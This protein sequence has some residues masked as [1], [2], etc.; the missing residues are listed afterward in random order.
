[1][2]PLFRHFVVLLA[3]SLVMGACPDRDPTDRPDVTNDVGNADVAD[4]TDATMDDT[5]VDTG[6]C[7]EPL[8]PEGR[9]AFPLGLAGAPVSLFGD[10]SAPTFEAAFD[11]FSANGINVF[12]PWFGTQEVDG[13]AT[14]SGHFDYFLP[15]AFSGATRNCGV[16]D[17]YA[18]AAGRL[19]IL[20]P[21]F[22]FSDAEVEEALDETVFRERFALFQSECW[23]DNE[24]V[25]V[26]HESF[27]EIATQRVIADF[28]ESPGPLLSNAPAAATLLHELSDAPVYLVEAP[29]PDV[30]AAEE[31]LTDAQKEEII[32]Q[33]WDGVD[34]VV[35]GVDVF[36]FD[37]YPVPSLPLELSGDY[38]QIAQERAPSAARHLAV[39]QG[40]SYDAETAGTDPRRG[41]TRDETRFMAYHA[42]T[43]GA[44]ELLWYGA[45]ALQISNDDHRN[46]WE[47]VEALT[48]ELGELGAILDGDRVEIE[49]GDLAAVGFRAASGAV[50]MVIVNPTSSNV[51]S[52][53]VTLPEGRTVAYDYE[54]TEPVSIVDRIVQLDIPAYGVRLLV[55]HSCEI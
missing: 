32:N 27:D 46:I 40:F 25:I 26:G 35:E 4:D 34:T 9:G 17:P 22:F 31:G 28:F 45:S 19:G 18:A 33:F 49:S 42:L 13:I 12:F 51:T 21:A 5:T 24:D 30:I 20:F 36:G 7:E 29:V 15:T 41:P 55:A 10:E 52:A 14:V 53:P 11:R 38:V 37:V 3:S 44:N 2:T 47:G 39:L 6:S 54:S 23:G 50:F 1:M 16:I 43:S 48:A 8:L